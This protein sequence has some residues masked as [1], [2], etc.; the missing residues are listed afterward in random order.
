[1]ILQGKELCKRV[2]TP[3]HKQARKME[4]KIS[5]LFSFKRTS[6]SKKFLTILELITMIG[7]KHAP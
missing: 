1:M 5:I 2:P 6:R 7:A 3:R 4:K